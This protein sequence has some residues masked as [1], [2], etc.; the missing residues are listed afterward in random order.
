MGSGQALDGLPSPGELWM[1]TSG[2][3]E[4]GPALVYKVTDSYIAAAPVTD[5][6]GYAFEGC[7][8]VPAERSHTGTPLLVFSQLANRHSPAD[9][10]HRLH[11]VCTPAEI[12]TMSRIA[13]GA[14]DPESGVLTILDDEAAEALMA[15][16]LAENP[17]T[18]HPVTAEDK[19]RMGA[20]FNGLE[21]RLQPVVEYALTFVQ[22]AAGTG[23]SQLIVR[24]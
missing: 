23:K 6:L 22:A 2:G 19:A 9:F 12:V 11:T 24:F 18:S 7:T 13:I 3:R 16:K 17:I 1:M 20:A 10:S 15:Q 8:L 21:P 4:I 5:K 14:A